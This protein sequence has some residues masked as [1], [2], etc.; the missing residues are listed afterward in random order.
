MRKPTVYMG[1]A[2]EKLLDV[3]AMSGE[4]QP[5]AWAGSGEKLLD[6]KAMPGKNQPYALAGS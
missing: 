3:M 2:Q 5:Y 1:W 6:A 4:N